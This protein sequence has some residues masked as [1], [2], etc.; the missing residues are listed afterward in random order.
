MFLK[1]FQIIFFIILSMT[2]CACVWHIEWGMADFAAALILV[3]SQISI[4]IYIITFGIYLLMH[5]SIRNTTT[6][7]IIATTT[8]LYAGDTTCCCC[9]CC[10]LWGSVERFYN[11]LWHCVL[12]SQRVFLFFLL[13]PPNI[14]WKAKGDKRMCHTY[15]CST[16]L[17]I[18]GSYKLQI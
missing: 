15:T 8:T 7:T 17:Y 14:N 13:S 11:I 9:C 12:H 18:C 16:L 4:E 3:V 10:G 6:T 1:Q 5:V 2:V